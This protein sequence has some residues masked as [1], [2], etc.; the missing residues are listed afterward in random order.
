VV[1][2]FN[3]DG[4]DPVAV[5]CATIETVRARLTDVGQFEN[6]SNSVK[7]AYARAAQRCIV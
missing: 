3:K 2:E 6:N 5:G 4:T 7:A 1:E